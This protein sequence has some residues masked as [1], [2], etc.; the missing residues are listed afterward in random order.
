MIAVD[1]DKILYRKYVSHVR[2]C[3]QQANRDCIMCFKLYELD[4]QKSFESHVQKHM[5]TTKSNLTIS[6]TTTVSTRDSANPPPSLIGADLNNNNKQKPPNV[7][8]NFNE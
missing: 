6:P 8:L 4:A 3:D 5:L 2:K 7:Y 1:A